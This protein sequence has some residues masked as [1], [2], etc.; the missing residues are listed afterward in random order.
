MA[1]GLKPMKKRYVDTPNGQI[2]VRHWLTPMAPTFLLLHW[3]PFSGRM[4]EPLGNYLAAL[5]YQVI[6]PDML[7][8]GRSDARPDPW[9]MQDW[10]RGALAVLQ[11]YEASQ[12][13]VVGGHNGASVATECAILGS[14]AIEQVVLDGCAILTPELRKAFAAMVKTERPKP[15]EDGSHVQ[16]V[17][18][19]MERVWQ[20]YIPG[21]SVE[22][23]A[24]LERM[25]PAMLDYLETDF[26]TSAPVSGAYDLT[27]R[28]GAISQPV[29]LLTAERDTLA[30]SFQTAKALLPQARSH[31][32]DGDHPLHFASRLDEYA[33]VLTQFFPLKA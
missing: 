16:L 15:L 3:T 7:G 22:T 8:Y 30:S 14:D 33:G 4:Y 19:R 29:L 2:H 21:F 26:Q 10:A 31:F 9:T 28:L 6:A 5:G 18:D 11:Q 32:F 13:C 24:D 20:E 27:E 17:W 23:K 12:T 1:Y 25:W